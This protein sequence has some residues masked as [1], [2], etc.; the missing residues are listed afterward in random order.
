MRF[1]II[2]S[3]KKST[4]KAFKKTLSLRKI[5]SIFKIVFRNIKKAFRKKRLL[6]NFGCSPFISG[7]NK[8]S[9]TPKGAYS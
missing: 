3:V 1:K 8:S 9:Y 7:V 5:P 4:Y 2:L 6:R